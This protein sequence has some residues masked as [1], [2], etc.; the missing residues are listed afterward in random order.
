MCIQLTLRDI[1]EDL[2]KEI[3]R[4]ARERGTSINKT[5]RE[6]LSES[7]GIDQSSG[8]K[9][10]LSDFAGFWDEEEAEEFDKATEVFE[11]VD[12]ELWK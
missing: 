11:K 5:I 1:P 3:R 2:E 6:L 12:E 7:L 4:I 10:D 9:R 8:K